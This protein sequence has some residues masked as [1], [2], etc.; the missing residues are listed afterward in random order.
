MDCSTAFRHHP[1][2][3]LIT[4]V[5][6]QILAVLLEISTAA[7]LFVALTSSLFALLTD[8]TIIPAGISSVET[9]MV[10]HYCKLPGAK[11]AL[12]GVNASIALVHIWIIMPTFRNRPTQSGLVK[13]GNQFNDLEST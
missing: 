10:V 1:V 11:L 9:I 4:Y 3:I 8:T 12:R 2:E 6:L 13:R 7:I 5:P